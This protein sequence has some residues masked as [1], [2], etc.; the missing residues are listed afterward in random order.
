MVKLCAEHLPNPMTRTLSLHIP[1]LVS[2][3]S[4]HIACPCSPKGVSSLC[5]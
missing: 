5:R 1:F 4:Q 2:P 3:T